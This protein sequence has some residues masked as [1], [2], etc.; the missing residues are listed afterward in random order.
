[1]TGMINLRRKK[2]LLEGVGKFYAYTVKYIKQLAVKCMHSSLWLSKDSEKTKKEAFRDL[3]KKEVKGRELRD[4]EREL[5]KGQL[6]T[7]YRGSWELRIQVLPYNQEASEG[8]GRCQEYR[9]GQAGFWT[10]TQKPSRKIR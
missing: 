1:M 3:T 4:E 9:P 8:P 6:S 10:Q 7:K 2:N 5:A